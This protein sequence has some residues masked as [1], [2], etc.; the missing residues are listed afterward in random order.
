MSSNDEGSGTPDPRGHEGAPE[1]PLDAP[2]ESA[3]ADPGAGPAAADDR[4]P[5]PAPGA[6]AELTSDEDRP[7][8][9]PDGITGEG[10]PDAAT[11]DGV[12]AVTV[13]SDE[14]AADVPVVDESPAPPAEGAAAGGDAP[15]DPPA[16][17]PGDVP[18]KVPAVRVTTSPTGETIPVGAGK[19]PAGDAAAAA[20]GATTPEQP[21]EPAAPASDATVTAAAADD[22][23]AGTTAAGEEIPADAAAGATTSTDAAVA[24]D[25]VP[26]NTEPGGTPAP[27]EPT[28]EAAAAEP[29]PVDEAPVEAPAAK[30]E[31]VDEAKPEPSAEEPEPEPVVDDDRQPLLD[32]LAAHLGDDLVATHVVPGRDMWARVTRA[33]WVKAGQICRDVLGMRYFGYLSAIDWMPS[34]FGRSEDGGLAGA[35]DDAAFVHVDPSS[36][37]PGITGGNTRFQVLA[38]LQTVGAPTIGLNLK[39]DVP[40]DDLVMPT[41]TK[42]FPGADWHER[43][44]AEMFGI[45]FSG[46]PHLVKLYLP[47]GFEGHPLRKD[48]PLLARDVKPWPGLVDV[49]PMPGEDAEDE[50]APA[51]AG[52]EEA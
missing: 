38:R 9:S 11:P 27:A 44:C 15:A 4:D 18:D 36:F 12:P 7:G 10:G 31:P 13:T 24:A 48:F 16:T 49:E 22:A 1:A 29:E 37:E 35:G 43:E 42:I 32:L 20:T 51:T 21:P 50:G 34:P 3:P 19:M 2:V 40:S 46:H 45:D 39:C 25:P 41:W 23:P 30:P 8:Q 6:P 17:P 28:A 5:M 52:A 33:G 14:A 47:G 26:V